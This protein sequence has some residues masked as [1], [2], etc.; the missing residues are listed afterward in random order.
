MYLHP[1]GGNGEVFLGWV[2]LAALFIALLC[3]TLP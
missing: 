1:N 3:K 2:V